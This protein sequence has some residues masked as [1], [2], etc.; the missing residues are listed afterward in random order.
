MQMATI[1]AVTT[2]FGFHWPDTDGKSKRN[3]EMVP[4]GMGNLGDQK[5]ILNIILVG[6]ENLAPRKIKTP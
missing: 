5:E 1:K 2:S 4:V 6:T 3:P